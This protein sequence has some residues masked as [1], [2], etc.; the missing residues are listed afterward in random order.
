MCM[1][2]KA[3]HTLKERDQRKTPLKKKRWQFAKQKKKEIPKIES[4]AGKLAAVVTHLAVALNPH[5]D[6]LSCSAGFVKAEKVSV[7][8]SPGHM[9]ACLGKLVL[10]SAG[11][12]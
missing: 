3:E 11:L 6:A 1:Q 5:R 12:P 7:T 9:M 8:V 4:Y 10:R 2:K